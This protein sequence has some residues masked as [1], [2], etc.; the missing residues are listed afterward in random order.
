MAHIDKIL[1]GESLVGEGPEVAHVEVMIGPRG[2]H[3]EHAWVSGLASQRAG[4]TNLMALITPNL[5]CRPYTLMVPKVT[6]KSGEQATLLF[7]AVQTG[8]ARAVADAVAEGTLPGEQAEDLYVI[9]G[10]FVQWD[11]KDKQKLQEWNYKATKEAIERAVAGY[12]SIR[13]VLEKKD[14]VTHPLA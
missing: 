1:I 10:I 6:I 4:H 11:A 5:P 12:P 2:S 9:A 8:V 7:G 13:E 3:V 14:K